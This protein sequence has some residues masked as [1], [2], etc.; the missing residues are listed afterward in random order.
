MRRV[1]RLE[2]RKECWE[3]VAGLV[4]AVG[5]GLV[6]GAGADLV[7]ATGLVS[8]RT[9]IYSAEGT[10]LRYAN[11]SVCVCVCVY[12]LC[13]RHKSLKHKSCPSPK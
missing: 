12:L 7:S 6:S 11:I 8:G 13:R 5:A 9:C 3:T 2:C 1:Q 10:R 4:S